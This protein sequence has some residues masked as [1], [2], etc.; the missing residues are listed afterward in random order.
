MSTGFT[1]KDGVEV[2]IGQHWRDQDKRMHGRVVEVVGLGD[3]ASVG[4]VRVRNAAGKER[5]LSVRRMH[6]HSTGFVLVPSSAPELPSPGSGK[7]SV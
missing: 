5:W 4:K 3:G 1:T 7:E 2:Q 6:K